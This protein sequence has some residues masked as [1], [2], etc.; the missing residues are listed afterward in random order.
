GQSAEIPRR[1]RANRTGSR[2]SL[3]PETVRL[4]TTNS[5]PPD[6]HIAGHEIGPAL[7]TGWGLGFAI[8]THPDFSLIPGSVGSFNWQGRWGTFFSVAGSVGSFNWQG[9]WCT[10]F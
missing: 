9:S 7:G 2:A 4:M 8:R 5:L 1:T 3:K 10:F 6:I